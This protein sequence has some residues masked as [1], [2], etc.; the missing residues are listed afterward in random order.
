VP[1]FYGNQVIDVR[2]LTPSS[3]R[4]YGDLLVH[5]IRLEE[6][7]L[8]HEIDFE[9]DTLLIYCRDFTHTEELLPDM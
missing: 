1:F 6:E 4:E 3:N 8:Y 2:W 9:H 5:E 7:Y